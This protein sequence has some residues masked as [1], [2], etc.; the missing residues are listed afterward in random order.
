M[1]NYLSTLSLAV[2]KKIFLILGSS[3]V[4]AVELK[5]ILGLLQNKVY[6]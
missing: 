2:E 4:S 5:A 1:I 6:M 3:K